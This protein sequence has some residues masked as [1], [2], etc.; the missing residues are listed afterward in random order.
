MVR[1][2]INPTTSLQV[3]TVN[4]DLYGSSQTYDCRYTNPDGSIL[5]DSFLEVELEHNPDFEIPVE[6]DKP[7]SYG[8][9]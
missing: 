8:K 2:I 7:L 1:L 4:H 3:I 9:L 6:E 5:R